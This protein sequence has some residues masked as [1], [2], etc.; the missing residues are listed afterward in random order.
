MH[1]V[2]LNDQ[3]AVAVV[4]TLLVLVAE[5]NQE[6]AEPL[7]DLDHKGDR[8]I[9]DV[10]LHLGDD[11]DGGELAQLGGVVLSLLVVDA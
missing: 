8:A 4:V 5:L 6:L 1:R 10:G 2:V 9:E 3:P 11:G 7:A